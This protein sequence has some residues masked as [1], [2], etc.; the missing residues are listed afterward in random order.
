MPEGHRQSAK[1]PNDR[2][3]RPKPLDTK[4][5]VEAAQV[6]REAVNGE[7]LATD[8]DQGSEADTRATHPVT[9]SHHDVEA[10]TRGDGETQALRKRGVNEHLGGDGIHQCTQ[11]YATY[12]HLQQHRVS[13]VESSESMEGDLQ[14]GDVPEGVQLVIPQV[15][16]KDAT[17]SRT[18]VLLAERLGAEVA[19]AVLPFFLHLGRR[20]TAKA[21]L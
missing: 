21:R 14:V 9:V 13:G 1:V 6:Q 18:L 8:D 16:E 4:H 10:S 2:A 11:L 20:E 17:P 15:H 12:C 3:Q 5:Q 7:G 19:L